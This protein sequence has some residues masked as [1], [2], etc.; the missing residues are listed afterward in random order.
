MSTVKQLALISMIK[1]M[2]KE[3]AQFI[4]ATHSP[5]LMAI[6]EATIISFDQHPIMQVSYNDLEQYLRHL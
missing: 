5:I 3:N 6:P 4:I 2:T 1:E